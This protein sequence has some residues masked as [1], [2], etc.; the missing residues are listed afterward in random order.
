MS[1][2]WSISIAKQPCVWEVYK[3][4]AVNSTVALI[5]NNVL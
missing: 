4:S 1:N 5:E 2:G 3:I